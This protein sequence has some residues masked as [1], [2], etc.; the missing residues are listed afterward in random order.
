M[1]VILVVLDTLRKDHVGAYGNDWIRT[2]NLD[3]FAQESVRFERAY[4]EAMPTIP[5]RNSLLT[6]KRVFPF[7]RWKAHL[8]SWPI[9]QWYGRREWNVPGWSP[10]D[11]DDVPMAEILVDK[12]YTTAMITDNFTYYYPGMNFHR[13]FQAF[14]W[15]RGQEWDS[16]QTDSLHNK[17]DV[18]EYLTEIVDPEHRQVRQRR[19]YLPNVAPRRTEEDYFAPQV[20]RE[21]TKWLE[22]NYKNDKFFLYVDSFDPHEPWDPPPYYTDL[23]SPDYKGK[24]VMTSIYTD[25]C[26]EW[27]NEE[28]L[29]RLRANYAGNVTLVDHWFGFF[30]E[31]VKLLGMDK[32]SLII[33]VADHGHQLGEKNFTGKV[34]WGLIPSILDIPLLIRHPD[35]VGAG[36]S[37]DAILMNH[38]ILPTICSLLGEDAPEWVEGEDFWPVV[39]GKKDKIRE[40]A[41][42]IFKDYLWVRN[43]DYAMQMKSDETEIQLFDLNKDP[44]Y[45]ENI[46]DGNDDI[47]QKMKEYIYEDA[48]GKVPILDA[49]FSAFDKKVDR[50]KGV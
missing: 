28:E 19:L 41:S 20:F 40:H 16:W 8:A 11:P 42:S 33:V 2:P 7:D 29:G 18:K 31:K 34:P 12:G 49:P 22:N 5:F 24:E 38:D 30:M 47:I 44:E 13:G 9:L 15:I 10:L 21:A 6:G 23:Y 43:D 25:D 3:R 4:P 32:N 45:L 36:K 48:G 37:C 39:E 1:N 46:A 50:K 17:P 14:E 35:G 27:L 26:T